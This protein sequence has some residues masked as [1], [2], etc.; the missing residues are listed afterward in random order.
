MKSKIEISTKPI[1]RFLVPVCCAALHLNGVESSQEVSAW[2]RLMAAVVKRPEA[3]TCQSPI[4]ASEQKDGGNVEPRVPLD[5]PKNFDAAMDS[6]FTE[7][8]KAVMQKDV[9]VA[10]GHANWNKPE[11]LAPIS[12]SI[13][14]G[15]KFCK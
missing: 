8:G 4:R 14:S 5:G 13:S 7:A 11:G 2:K 15:G 10:A 12:L 3:A 9:R 1:I 6:V